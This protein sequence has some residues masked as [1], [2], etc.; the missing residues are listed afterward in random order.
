MDFFLLGH[1]TRQKVRWERQAH[2]SEGLAALM[3]HEAVAAAASSSLPPAT[4][5]EAKALAG[6]KRK[7]KRR[8]SN[9]R[10]M[11]QRDGLGKREALLRYLEMQQQ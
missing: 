8:S 4:A 1:C 5:P 3:W 7:R 9:V 11:R 6:L 10:E 2:I